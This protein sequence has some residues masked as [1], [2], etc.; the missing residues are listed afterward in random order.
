MAKGFKFK[1]APVLRLQELKE[2]QVKNE[3][4]VIIRNINHKIQ[5]I[6]KYR[7]EIRFYFSRYEQSENLRGNMTAGLRQYMPEFLVTHYDKIKKCRS[8][9]EDLNY[10]KDELI[11]KLAVAKGQVKIF[12]NLRDKKYQTYKK[13]YDSKIEREIEEF[14]ILKGGK[15]E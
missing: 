10:K 5:M 13:N 2:D 9:L 4:G 11:Q 15:N 1:L 12:T 7:E 8:E 6:D 3:L 14:I